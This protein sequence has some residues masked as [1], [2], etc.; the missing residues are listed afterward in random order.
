M[1]PRPPCFA[2]GA[3]ATSVV[4]G[5][6]PTKSRMRARTRGSCAHATFAQ[7]SR[8]RRS[9][10]GR[11]AGEGSQAWGLAGAGASPALLAQLSSQAESL[12]QMEAANAWAQWGQ[13]APQMAPPMPPGSPQLASSTRTNP[14]LP[15]I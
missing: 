15:E 5:A 10:S 8:V 1:P 4:A 11:S 13:M 3:E 6:T 7:K 12:R 9:Y 14:R 2:A